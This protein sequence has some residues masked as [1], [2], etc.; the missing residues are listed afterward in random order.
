MIPAH[1]CE[2]DPR[3]TLHVVVV[4]AVLVAV[5]LEQVHGVRTRPI[6]EVN[7][8]LREHVLYCLDELVNKRKKIRCGRARLAHTQVQGIVQILLVIGTGVEIHGEQ[9]L[10]RHSGAGSVELQLADGYAR[11]VCAEVAKA[12]D[13]A[14]VRDADEPNVF[15]RPVFQNLLYLAAPRYRQIHAT[16]LAVDMAELQACFADGRVVHNREK[17]RRVRHDGS[18]EER[19]VVVEQIHE[20]DIAFQIRVL[21]REL[22]IHSLQL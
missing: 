6:F 7:A 3:R 4:D 12:K 17:A 8:T 11:A 2:S 16:R 14:A 18:V 9:V 20:V 19:L 1:P 10:R 13:P 15:L 22:Q 5:A 21:L